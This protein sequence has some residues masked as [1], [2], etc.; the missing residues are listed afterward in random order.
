VIR[1]RRAHPRGD[2]I[3]GLVAAQDAEG[4]QLSDAEVISAV[5]LLLFAGNV[6]TTDVANGLFALLQNP[7]QLSVLQSDRSLIGNAVEEILRFDPPVVLADRIATTDFDLDG[8]L[9]KAGQWLSAGLS[10][11]NRD[12]SIHADPERFDLRRDPI[13]HVAFGGGRHLCFGAP[14]ARTE[15]QVAISSLISRF[16]EIRLADPSATPT[17]KY[18]PGF[19]G[20]ADLYVALS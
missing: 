14:L 8:C 12:P 17:C 13:H 1:A 9:I 10:S 11:A 20:L 3:S 18:A 5:A 2:L 19:H 6:T 4:S 15:T 7:D 16:P